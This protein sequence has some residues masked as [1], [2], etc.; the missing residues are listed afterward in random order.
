[1]Q[2]R[3]RLPAFA[4]TRNRR[5]ERRVGVTAQQGEVNGRGR[6]RVVRCEC[7]EPI[8]QRDRTVE[9]AAARDGNERVDEVRPVRL[10]G[11]LETRHQHRQP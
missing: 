6:R 4:V 3:Q 9:I 11:R 8:T 5:V 2:V 10:V 1:V 7:C